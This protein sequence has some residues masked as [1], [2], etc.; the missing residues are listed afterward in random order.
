MTEDTFPKYYAE[1]RIVFPG[2]YDFLN[3]SKPAFRYFKEDDEAKAGDLFGFIPV[4]TNF[5]IEIGMSQDG[6]KDFGELFE[7]KLFSFPKPVELI[8][9]ILKAS[10]NFDK[11]SIILDFFSGSATTAHAIMQLNAE[12]GGHRKFIMIQLP[13]NL[14]KLLLVLVWMRD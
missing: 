2:D 4:S 3:I 13:E 8:K 10:T 11:D 1:N 6:T 9:H 14:N 5:P 7:N 12:D